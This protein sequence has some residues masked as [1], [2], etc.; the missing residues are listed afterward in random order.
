MSFLQR[1]SQQ[2]L[3]LIAPISTEMCATSTNTVV[4]NSNWIS[5]TRVVKL[6]RFAS[7]IFFIVRREFLR[8]RV[9]EPVYRSHYRVVKRVLFLHLLLGLSTALSLLKMK[10]GPGYATLVP[11]TCFLSDTKLNYLPT[12]Y[13]FYII[14]W[15][16]FTIL[17]CIYYMYF[18][19]N[20]DWL[21]IEMQAFFI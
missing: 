17:I 9:I 10:M 8:M 6:L 21:K 15:K 7:S 20:A 13:R 14:W 5:I 19:S 4:I 2:S 3:S 1:N 11:K 12:I 18:N 16:S